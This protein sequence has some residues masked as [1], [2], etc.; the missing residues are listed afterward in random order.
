MGPGRGAEVARGTAGAAR[1]RPRGRTAPRTDSGSHQSA[2]PG[3]SGNPVAHR[4]GAALALPRDR[5]PARGERS[6]PLPFSSTRTLAEWGPLLPEQVL[7][8]RVSDREALTLPS[9]TPA[10]PHHARACYKARRRAA[11]P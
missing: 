3:R 4:H 8:P 7:V 9:K 6:G 5:R 11:T 1:S 10:R 2:D